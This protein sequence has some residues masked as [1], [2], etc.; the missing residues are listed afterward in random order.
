MAELI[1][2]KGLSPFQSLSFDDLIGLTESVDGPVT[3]DTEGVEKMLGF[4]LCFDGIP[5]GFYLPFNH[6]KD[7][8]TPAQIEKIFSILHAKPA[9]VMHNAFHDLAVLARNGFEYRGKFYDT[10]LMAHWIDEEMMSYRLNDV[11]QAY[12]GKPKE[13]PKIM[14][15]II[16]QEGWD[17]VPVQWMT[18]YSG[19]DAYIEHQLFNK[20]LPKF[21]EEGFDDG[22]WDWE[23]AFIREVMYPMKDLGIKIDLGFCITEILKGKVVMNQCREFLGINPGST[24]QLKT[25]LIDELGLPI[26]SLTPKGKPQFNKDNMEKYEVLL[27]KKNDKRAETILRYRGWQKTISANYQSYINHVDEFGI[28][29]PGYKLHGTKTGR[30]SCADPALQQIPK[31]SDK[32]WNG[33]SKRAFIAREG[34]D[35]WTVD[36]SQLQFRM[37]CSYAN[38]RTLIEIFN[39]P[40]RDIFSEMAKQMGW[41]RPDVKTLVYLMLFGGGANRAKDAFGVPLEQAKEII[42]EFYTHYPELKKIAK[43]AQK[44]ATRQGHIQ[45]WTGRRK[46]FPKGSKFYRAFNAAIQGGEAEIMKRAMIQL[47]REVCNDEYRMVLQI[48]DELAFEIKVGKEKEYLP[49]IQKVMEEVPKTFC[50]FTE[51][52]VAFATEAKKWGEK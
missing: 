23:Q 2:M 31:S 49:R 29:H 21:K 36:Y 19:N 43:E 9:L 5:D 35:L 27:E 32:E 33:H 42:N 6:A 30:L 20:L 15:D 45:Y 51:V 47:A 46:H 1:P 39:D 24:T 37:A 38:C 11:S 40:T 41:T 28:L 44:I 22:L 14:R 50:E 16:D 25:L 17:A 8:L 10:M 13:M 3:I 52:P 4:S 18:I 48:H 12:G 26:L 7:N 34:Y